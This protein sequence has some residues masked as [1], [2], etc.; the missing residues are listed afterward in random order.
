MNPLKR[1]GEYLSSEPL[2]GT[3]KNHL[4]GW[5]GLSLCLAGAGRVLIG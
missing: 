3:L 1:D 5:E 4:V 2:V